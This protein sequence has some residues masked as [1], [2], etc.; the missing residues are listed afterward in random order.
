MR[1]V[2]APLLVVDD[3]PTNRDMLSRR[4]VRSG[5]SVETSAS[6]PEALARLERGP[7]ELV[8]LDVQMPGMSGLEVLRT[9]RTTR[10]SSVLPVLMVTAK[11]QSE[12][13]VA[14][15]ELGAD[16]YV[17]KP[18]DYPVALARIR[19]QLARKRAEERLRVSEERYALAAQGANDGLWD[20]DLTSGHVYFSSRWKAIVGCTDEE[21]GVEPIE[22]LGRVHI[23]DAGRVKQVLEAHLAGQ[24]PHFES[25]YRIRHNSGAFRWVLARGLAVR[26]AEGVAVRI[27][28]SQ[29]DLTDSKV[30][31]PLT[32]LPNRLLLQDRLDQALRHHRPQD[33]RF[34][35]VLFID[36]DD[37]KRINDSLGSYAGDELLQSVARRLERVLRASDTVARA[38]SLSSDLPFVLEHTLARLGGDEFIVLLHDVRS[39]VDVSRVTDRIQLGLTE[40]FTLSGQDVFMS[41]SVGV[42]LSCDQRHGPQAIIEDAHTAM[43]RAKSAG[44]GRAEVFDAAMRAEV[45]ERLQLD[46]ALRQALLRDEFLPYYQPIIDLNTGR[47]AGFEA[48]LRWRHPTRGMVMPSE[49]IPVI[50]EN[51]LVTPIGRQFFEHVCRDLRAWQEQ[52]PA[53][54]RLWVNVNFASQ[55]FL[56][57]GLAARLAQSLAETGLSP[58]Q[59]V[60]EITERTAITNPALT[61]Q[62]FE[63]LRE[64]GFRVVMDDFGTGYSSLADLHRLPISGLKLDPAFIETCDRHPALLKTVIALSESLQLSVTAEGI[65]SLEQCDR[66]RSVG[67]EFGQGYL[68]ERPVPA[69]RAAAIV[70]EDRIWLS[71]ES[72]VTAGARPLAGVRSSR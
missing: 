53:G 22:W 37:F 7:V 55:Q 23:E 41:A 71:A 8:L 2:Q 62:V 68:F 25:E 51:G 14:A 17:T 4:L 64:A 36:L 48:L 33:G 38:S 21:I 58:L 12:D 28:G 5:F 20:W 15:L 54:G 42:A 65:E 52:Y 13:I 66:L 49:F 35:A 45:T 18:I 56:E 1:D 70:A 43:A 44:T 47:L 27:A 6:G 46:T 10:P 50:E 9:I 69:E 60:I 67:C 11:D 40:P 16:D 31:D 63:Q 59:I 72:P 30:V 32:G 19:T 3:D 57:E 34:C 61:L 29:A 24:A 26:N 39:A